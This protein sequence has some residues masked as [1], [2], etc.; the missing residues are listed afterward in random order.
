MKT[1]DRKTPTAKESQ[2][3]RFS[4][5]KWTGTGL[6][7]ETGESASESEVGK[8]L[9]NFARATAKPRTD[10]KRSKVFIVPNRRFD[11]IDELASSDLNVE[12]V[13]V[14]FLMT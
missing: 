6:E 4:M 12:R 9:A 1:A 2:G 8:V 10:S 5:V 13:R 11:R 14:R 7:S 3:T